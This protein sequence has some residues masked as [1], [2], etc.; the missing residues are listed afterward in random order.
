MNLLKKF[1]AQKLQN[2]EENPLEYWEEKSYMLAIPSEE[3]YHFNPQ[4]ILKKIKSIK[5]VKFLGE[6]FEILEAVYYI[7]LSYQNN[8]YEVGLFLRDFTLPEMYL[9]H[10][11]YFTDAEITKLKNASQ[12]LN[13]FMEFSKDAQDSFHLQLKIITA[14]VPDLI[15]VV[16][17]SAERVLPAKWVLMAANSEVRPGPKDLFNVHAV[18]SK[19]GEIWLHTHGLCRCHQTELEILQT[20]KERFNF[21]H[22]LIIAYASFLIEEEDF[23]PRSESTYIGMLKNNIPVIVICIPWPQA[24]LQYSKL[25][26]GGL[27]DRENGH[28]TKTSPIFLYQSEED[29]KNKVLSK[30]SIYNDLWVNDPIFFFS[31]KETERMKALAVERFAYLKKAALSKDNHIIVKIGLP[32]DDGPDNENIWFELLEFKGEKFKAKLTQEPYNV[33]SIK[34]G[35]ERWFT[36]EDLIDFEIYT[37]KAQI[38]PDDVYLLDE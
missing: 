13:V 28:N 36:K 24:L 30:V 6:R 34:L 11:F 16:D 19:K 10:G 2:I 35:D 23:D 26:V 31:N 32:T 9:N 27:Q 18:I 14:L 33:S 4:E 3:N 8:D 12:S 1:N 37:N 29:E 5:G 21:L 7:K 25:T 15:G 20:D 17:E 22:D 38:S